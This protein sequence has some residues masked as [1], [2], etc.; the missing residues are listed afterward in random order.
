MPLF[1]DGIESELPLLE[2]EALLLVDDA[3]S[4]P[5]LLDGVLD[6]LDIIEALGGL[7]LEEIELVRLE[8][9]PFDN[10]PE[11]LL[12]DLEEVDCDT[13][14]EDGKDA[15][16]DCEV[17]L[18]LD[19]RNPELDCEVLLE[20]DEEIPELDCEVPLEL[21]WGGPE[22]LCEVLLELGFDEELLVLSGVLLLVIDVELLL[23]LGRVVPET[24]ELLDEVTVLELENDVPESLRLLDDVIMALELEVVVL[25]MPVLAELGN[26]LDELD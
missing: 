22:L 21:D 3:E 19:R 7:W 4:G 8:L 10:D 5:P 14:L 2:D 13:L 23:E 16:V 15:E 11:P 1:A 6:K 9:D 12:L 17:L 20:L 25:E 18:E 26:V 24:L